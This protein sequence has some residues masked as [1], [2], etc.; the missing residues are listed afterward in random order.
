VFLGDRSTS[1]KNLGR[2]VGKATR[3]HGDVEHKG[4]RPEERRGPCAAPAYLGRSF[5]DACLLLR[6]GPRLLWDLHH[7]RISRSRNADFHR[8]AFSGARHI[9]CDAGLGGALTA[10]PI[11]VRSAGQLP[12][13]APEAQL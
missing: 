2:S 5:W 6:I 10:P 9:A 7:G 1:K 4:T 12:C 11:L 3:Q 8:R 13:K